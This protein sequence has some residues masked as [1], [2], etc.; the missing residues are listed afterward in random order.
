M[1]AVSKEDVPT[2]SSALQNALIE[3]LSARIQMLLGHD[4]FL[5]CLGGPKWNTVLLNEFVISFSL[6]ARFFAAIDSCYGYDERLLV[7]EIERL[8]EFHFGDNAAVDV[9]QSTE[10]RADHESCRITESIADA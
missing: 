9:S 5:P 1:E 2:S 6:N 4:G 8:F 7:N 3:S 10:T